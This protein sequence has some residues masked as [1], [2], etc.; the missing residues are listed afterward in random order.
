VRGQCIEQRRLS[1]PGAARDQDVALAID[2][3]PKAIGHA[4]RERADLDQLAQCEPSREFANGQDRS[5]DSARREHRGDTRT[6]LEPGVEQRLHVGDLIAAR[7]GDIL[8]GN[9][10]IP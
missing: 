6:V 9:R 5:R 10:Q 8:D 3:V 7:T 1:R 2:G 4:R